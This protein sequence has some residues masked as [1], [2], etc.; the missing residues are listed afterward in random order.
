MKRLTFGVESSPYI[1]T[2]VIQHLAETHPSLYPEASKAILH[3]FYVDNFISGAEAIPEAEQLRQRLCELLLKAG[4]TLR[5]WRTSSDDLRQLIPKDLT[6]TEDLIL[7]EPTQLLRPWEFTGM[8]PKITF[9]FLRLPVSQLT[10]SPKDLLPQTL[11]ECLTSS[12]CLRL[13]SFQQKLCSNLFG[14]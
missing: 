13:P 9:T 1:A 14:N 12:D 10:K 6:E 4:M 5:K 7:A 3:G 11:L 8:S 2:Q